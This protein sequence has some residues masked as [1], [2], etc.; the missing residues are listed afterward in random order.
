MSEKRLSTKMARQNAPT[1]GGVKSTWEMFVGKRALDAPPVQFNEWLSFYSAACLSEYP[2]REW[3]DLDIAIHEGAHYAVSQFQGDT[4]GR[5]EEQLYQ[6][7]YGQLWRAADTSTY[8]F[9]SETIV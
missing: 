6:V 4:R 5:E 7:A 3:L 8:L 1:A 2:F 9:N